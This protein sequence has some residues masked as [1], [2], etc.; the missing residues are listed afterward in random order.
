MTYIKYLLNCKKFISLMILF[1]FFDNFGMEEEEKINLQDEN[2]EYNNSFDEN[3]KI[4]PKLY[5]CFLGD[6]GVG[7]TCILHS[8]LGHPFNKS[9]EST[10]AL[11]FSSIN[12]TIDNQTASL[13]FWDCSGQ[14]RYRFMSQFRYEKSNLFVLVYSVTDKRSFESLGG[15]LDDVKKKNSD[16]KF[17]LV[18]NKIDEP[19]EKRVVTEEEGKNFAEKNKMKFLEVSAKTGD[20]ISVNLFVPF[21][22]INL[23]E[24]T[25]KK[26][27]SFANDEC[28]SCC[29]CF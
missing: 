6:S 16:A 20:N 9:Q 3:D 23:E 4:F 24:N 7:K 28:C 10:I 21:F 15:W 26:K 25:G 13:L 11:V 5:V 1:S 14:E 22:N 12:V 17:L 8:L 18:G 2:N 29:P 27:V 19:G